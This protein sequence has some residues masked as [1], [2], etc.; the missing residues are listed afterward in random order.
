MIA[1]VSANQSHTVRKRHS[2]CS[3]WWPCQSLRTRQFWNQAPFLRGVTQIPASIRYGGCVKSYLS[4]F[5]LIKRVMHAA[6]YNAVYRL[7]S[8]GPKPDY[9]M[10]CRPAG[11]ARATRG[12]RNASRAPREVMACIHRVFM[13]LSNVN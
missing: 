12:I 6:H 4:G 7:T 13:H 1:I 5:H 9:S 8:L 10:L 2:S 3:Q 11:R